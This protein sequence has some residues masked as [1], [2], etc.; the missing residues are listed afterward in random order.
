MSTSFNLTQQVKEFLK[1][2]QNVWPLLRTNM[3]ALSGV[4]T[5]T[6]SYD[7]HSIQLQFNPER[8]RSTGAK[9]DA[10]S[11][12]ER[13]CFLCGKNRPSEQ[14]SIPFEQ[15]YLILC[16]P[17]PIFHEHLTITH[18]EHIPQNIRE[19]FPWMLKIARQLPEMVV[20]YNGPRCGASAPDHFHFQA[21]EKYR[22]PIDNEYENLKKIYG[23]LLW[24]SGSESLISLD[25]TC[26]KM[27]CIESPD[28]ENAT[29][30]FNTIYKLLPNPEAGEEA[31]MNILCSW[32]KNHFRIIIIPRGKHRPSDYFRTGEDKITISP[33]SVD[34]GGLIITPVQA[35]FEKL[36]PEKITGIIREVCLDDNQFKLLLSDLQMVL[37]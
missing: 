9:V 10:A 23:S 17:Y 14:F 35:D 5:R 13:A 12:A 3:A 2:Q 37:S 7:H 32:M 6:F 31:M 15:D 30:L 20:F 28:P 11:I 29:N 27:L 36:T 33:A 18:R 34:L 26:R 16:N 22:M 21:G 19:H 25:D 8:I 24:K 4:Q 1:D